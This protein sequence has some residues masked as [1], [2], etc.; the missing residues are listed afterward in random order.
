MPD[1][2]A[3]HRSKIAQVCRENGV[4]RL[5]LFGS[6]A[7]G[8]FIAG[9]SDLDFYVDLGEYDQ[10]VGRRYARLA[11]VLIDLFGEDIDLLTTRSVKKTWLR[12]EIER[13]RVPLF[14]A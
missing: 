9:K 14:V 6:G 13:T 2:V 8:A 12:D 7:T 1:V 5:D 3:M 11:V 10:F 4:R